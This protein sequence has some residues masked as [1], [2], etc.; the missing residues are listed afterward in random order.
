MIR[1]PR[2]LRPYSVSAT[3]ILDLF[4]VA[5]MREHHYLAVAGVQP[6]FY[7]ENLLLCSD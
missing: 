2:K 5:D 1:L 4:S 7:E 3:C 6:Q